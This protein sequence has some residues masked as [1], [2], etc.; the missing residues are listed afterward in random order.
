IR[1]YTI[2]YGISR[3]DK[4]IDEFPEIKIDDLSVTFNNRLLESKIVIS[5]T[6]Q[7]TYLQS[8]AINK[9]TIIF[10]NPEASEIKSEVKPYIDRLMD[11]GIY[12]TSPK[13]A[14]EM[15]SNIYPTIDEW[16]YS[17]N[18]QKAK[19]AFCE[20]FAYTSENWLQ[21]WE[22]ALSDLK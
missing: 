4:I 10:W 9:P 22:L 13:S 8:L 20:K 21:E 7:T 2:D 16:W 11:V 6:N 19:N 15:L 5:D 17:S 1:L 12:H 14:A 3:N 18:T